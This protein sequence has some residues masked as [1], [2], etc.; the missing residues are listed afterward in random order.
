MRFSESFLEQVLDR[1]NIV[2]IISQYT[3]LKPTGN[4]FMGRC[5]FPQHSEKTASF[6]VSERKQVYYC[7]GCQRRGN[8]FSFLKEYNGMSFVE[9]VEYLADRAGLELPSPSPDD[10]E[11]ETRDQKKRIYE[12]NQMAV[13]FFQSQLHKLIPQSPAYLYMQK[14]KLSA[15]LI[16]EFELGVSGPEWDALTRFLRMKGFSE[17]ELIEARLIRKRTQGDGCYDLFRDRIMFPIRSARGEVVGFGGRI[18]GEGE[19]KYLNSPESLVFHKGR[20]LYGLHQSA[21]F[22]RSEDRVV[23]VEGY[24]D[25]LALY[26]AGIRSVAATLGTALTPDHG[27]LLRKLTRNVIV[28]F[29]G[30]RAGLAAMER[31]LPILLE[32]E[33]LPRGLVLENEYDPDEYIQDHGAVALEERLNA[34]SDLFKLVL[35]SWMK[36]YSGEVQEKVKILERVQPLLLAIR[37]TQ[38]RALYLKEVAQRMG[39][40]EKWLEQSLNSEDRKLLPTALTGTQAA[41]EK[42]NRG[43]TKRPEI[44]GNS[45]ALER[46]SLVGS[47]AAELIILQLALHYKGHLE[48]IQNQNIIEDLTH[49]GIRALLRKLIEFHNSGVKKF[50]S[51]LA[52][53]AT[54]VDRPE[55]LLGGGDLNQLQEFS[56][57]EVDAEKEARLLHDSFR[58][59]RSDAIQKRIDALAAKIKTAVNI[60]AQEKSEL[61]TE[62]VQLQRLKLKTKDNVK[63]EGLKG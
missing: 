9:A 12:A 50:D 5:P 43:Q 22:I 14:R 36:S 17:A 28:L 34:A 4:G 44:K 49:E 41:S 63:E 30:D 62:L 27:R 1:S 42:Q 16:D 8:I 3:Q 48:L 37:N 38:I 20:T 57:D 55:L 32:A 53:A 10:P 35:A 59:I 15:T 52:I 26:G 7:F 21:K 18:Y 2:D 61:L 47:P 51:A 58:R 29:D 46:I 45:E 54:W 33:L 60:S 31:S 24:M 56:I 39:V 13:Q 6:S 11:N 19:P 23:I 25:F 40:S